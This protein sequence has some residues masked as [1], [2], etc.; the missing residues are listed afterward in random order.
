MG[1]ITLEEFQNP[2]ADY[3]G[4]PFFAWN[5]RI[6][7]EVVKE[8]LGEYQAMGMG[9]C[10][11]HSRIG[12]DTEYLGKEFM[13]MVRL[14]VD[15]NKANGMH[16]ILYDEDKWPSGYGGGRA[17][18]EERFKRRYLL[19]SPHIY[20]DGPFH[21]NRKP[22]TRLVLDGTINRLAAYQVILEDGYLKEYRRLRE[23]EDETSGLWYAYRV[24][25]GPS[26]WFN[27]AS[28]LDTLNQEAVKE[29]IKVAY[30]PYAKELGDEFA[31]SIPAIFTDEPQFTL[32]ENFQCSD[33]MEEAGIPYT[34]GFGELFGK[35]YGQSFLDHLPELFW[36]KKNQKDYSFR[37]RYHDLTAEQFCR[38]YVDTIGGW[39]E[40]HGI[41]LTGHVMN[42]P[43]LDS[44]SRA[45]GEAMRTYR[46]FGIPGVDILAWR[47][48][49]NTI[50]Q[51]QS[52]VH[53][54]GRKGLT[55]EL[56][57]ATNWDFDFRGHK[58]M[59]DWQAALGVTHR[60]HHVSWYSMNG[61]AKRDYPA[62]IDGHSPWYQEYGQIESYFARIR[63]AMEQGSPMVRIGV[64]H[65]IESCWMSFGPD[66]KTG[67]VRQ[68]MDR[69]FE[70]LTQ[71]LLFGSLDFDFIAESSLTELY[72]GCGGGKVAVGAMR[73]DVVLV[74]SL[75]TIRS[76]T[77]AMLRE[78]AG[79]GGSV[80]F[81]GGLPGFVD[82]VENRTVELWA[83]REKHCIQVPFEQRLVLEALEPY[84][85]VRILEEGGPCMD[86]F[87]QLREDEGSKERWLF[88][89][90]GRPDQKYVDSKERHRE[91]A[92][93]GC[94]RC[95]FPDPV[96]GGMKELSWSVKGGETR[97]RWNCHDQDSLLVHLVRVSDD[98]SEQEK[99]GMDSREKPDRMTVM[100]TS[101]L[102]PVRYT[103]AEPNVLLLDQPCYALDRKE[104]RGPEEILRLDDRLRTELGYTLR[105]E[106]Y[107]QPWL[108]PKKGNA[109]HQI[110]LKFLIR[111]ECGGLPVRAAVEG[112]PE[113]VLWNGEDVT[114]RR[115]GWYVDRCYDMWKLGA[116]R[117]G[118]NELLLDFPYGEAANL[119]WCY[120]LGG[121]GT[122]VEGSRTVLTELPDKIYY[123][124]ITKQGLAFYGGSLDYVLE[125]E[126]PEGEL[127]VEIPGY[128]AP[129]LRVIL[130]GTV[131][132]A[133][134][135]AP[136][137][138]NLGRISRGRHEIRIVSYGNR[139]NTFGPLHNANIKEQYIGPKTWRTSGCFWTYGYRLKPAGILKA[140]VIRIRN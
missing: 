111:S 110:S 85:E 27:N 101:S 114:P 78:L 31:G 67:Q 46:S 36:E 80:V 64:I 75:R 104:W 125:A 55:S 140:P 129:L 90:K 38:S 63:M 26:P 59:G 122:Q 112:K 3:R 4:T 77:L 117:K 57:G 138:V 6:G 71:W 97:I 91:I 120:L 128:Q 13:E 34:D 82:G 60:V 131:S 116:L 96:S 44:Q 118:E 126:L 30:E 79:Q 70:A 98:E 40:D 95:A 20:Q 37:C 24:V 135:T 50:K 119:E 123:G 33:G 39:C 22:R 115:D 11:V 8:R 32:K 127:E 72:G 136:Y 14:C 29:F 17:A 61:E 100:A 105:T 53:Q 65:P 7:A 94:F 106:S 51:A 18:R 41:S 113:R 66:D 134:I 23:G 47:L 48:E 108:T 124:D 73:Y 56:Y 121:F 45:V 49:Y 92:V 132:E 42:E 28:Y 69:R 16:T 93:K 109:D 133:V 102:F 1:K 52:A 35:V 81:A 58:G 84:R 15:T 25:T 89:A 83:S 107:P 19:F 21:R 2:G 10:C 76:T 139:H 99:T 130:D 62:P 43:T 137:R 5:S 103:L 12:L 54:Y 86:Y 9:G 74:P 87:Y 88:L 68:E